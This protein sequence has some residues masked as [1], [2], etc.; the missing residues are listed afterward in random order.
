MADMASMEYRRIPKATFKTS[1][2][3][4]IPE[5]QGSLSGHNFLKFCFFC[6]PHNFSDFSSLRFCLGL[7]PGPRLLRLHTAASGSREWP[8]RGCPTASRG[9]GGR[10]CGEQ[11]IWPWPRTR[12]R[13]KPPEGCDREK[14]EEML[15]VIQIH[16]LWKISQIIC[17]NIW[18]CSLSL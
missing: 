9:Q 4:N 13:G 3:Y 15:I 18:L 2:T 1:E 12:I 5:V 7:G 14:V 8:R 10:G 16:T 6:G 11:Q 17:T